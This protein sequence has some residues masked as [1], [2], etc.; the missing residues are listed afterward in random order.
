MF[1]GKK[2]HLISQHFLLYLLEQSSIYPRCIT[3]P[4]NFL[5]LSL[6]GYLTKSARTHTHV[7]YTFI[8][9]A[10]KTKRL[11]TPNIKSKL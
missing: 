1:R 7:S 8:F 4:K 6:K 3:K 9:H 5:P 10:G 2:T 11:F